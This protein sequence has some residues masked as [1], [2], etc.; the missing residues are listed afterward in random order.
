VG[1]GGGVAEGRGLLRGGMR[2]LIGTRSEFLT[3]TGREDSLIGGFVSG[4]EWRTLQRVEADSPCW[5]TMK[6]VGAACLCA[7]LGMRTKSP[8]LGGFDGRVGSGLGLSCMF[9]SLSLESDRERLEPSEKSLENWTSLAVRPDF[10]IL[11][12]RLQVAM[13]SSGTVMALDSGQ[14]FLI[15]VWSS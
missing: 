6:G 8:G 7:V 11:L 1:E 13:A 10:L 15:S 3:V 5:V 14:I 4:W 9:F 12:L 2:G